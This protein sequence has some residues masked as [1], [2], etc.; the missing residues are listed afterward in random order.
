MAVGMLPI[1]SDPDFP[2]ACFSPLNSEPG[3]VTGERVALRMF[4]R[5]GGLAGGT[6][7]FIV[8]GF[9]IGSGGIMGASGGAIFE[10]AKDVN[11]ILSLLLLLIILVLL[12]VIIL[13]LDTD[14]EP[15]A[16]GVILFVL[17]LFVLLLLLLLL[18]LIMK[19]GKVLVA[20]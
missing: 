5:T 16:R 15:A 1:S 11:F 10:G 8:V 19:G 4:V 12:L 20:G 9:V 7:L 14:A 17:L 2:G 3:V 6:T 13:L 18:L